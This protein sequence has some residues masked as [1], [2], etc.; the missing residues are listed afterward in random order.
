MVGGTVSEVVESKHPNFKPG[1]YV[2]GY[3]RLSTHAISTAPAF[4]HWIP[5]SHRFRRRSACSACRE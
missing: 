1:D 2:Q 3:N 5:R 4:A